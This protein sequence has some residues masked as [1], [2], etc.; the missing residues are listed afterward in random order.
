MQ[1][2]KVL[3]IGIENKEK[4]KKKK[5]KKQPWFREISSKK[6]IANFQR[7]DWIATWEFY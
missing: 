4:I 3:M 5:K 2:W 7:I 6:N 1:F